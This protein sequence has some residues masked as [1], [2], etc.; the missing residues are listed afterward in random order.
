MDF[1]GNW[2][3]I[4]IMTVY[5]SV[6]QKQ[7]TRLCWHGPKTCHISSEYERELMFMIMYHCLSTFPGFSYLLVWM[8]LL[9]DIKKTGNFSPSFYSCFLNIKLSREY[10]MV[11]KFMMCFT[12]CWVKIVFW[13]HILNYWKCIQNCL[14][15]LN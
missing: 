2:K 3:K 8:Q 9:A 14:E 13:K 11:N 10:L 1:N 5:L 12:L 7:Q 15:K 6:S 4:W